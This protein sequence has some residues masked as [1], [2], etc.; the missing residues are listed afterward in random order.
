[1]KRCIQYSSS[2]IVA[3]S[4]V[5][6]GQGEGASG[7]PEA[8]G[9]VPAREVVVYVSTDEAIA[10]PILDAFTAE[11]G[12]AVRA[13]YD[14]ENAKTTAL[15]AMLR[16]ER[17]APRADVFWSGECFA[18]AQLGRE[19]VM[20]AWRSQRGDRFP[21]FLRG[22][23]GKW[24]GFAPRIRV[25]VYDPRQTSSEQ[26]PKSMIDLA[27]PLALE[28]GRFVSKP[29]IAIAD[30]RF[31]T[32][33]GHIGAFASGMES[34]EAGSFAKW[35]VGFS[36]NRPLILSGGNAAVVDAVVRGQA[37]FGLTDSDDVY[38]AVANGANLAMIP[39]RQ[40]PLG[41]VGG[42]PMRVP[43]SVSLVA[44][45][46]NPVE[47]NA[48]ILF[49]LQPMVTKWMHDSRSGNLIVAE[50]E[51]IDLESGGATQPLVPPPANLALMQPEVLRI[52]IDAVEDPFQYDEAMTLESIDSSVALLRQSCLAQ[53]SK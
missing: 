17:D 22:E 44:G 9:E 16:D 19:G 28:L 26:L 41:E 43:N 36:S 52:R 33:R 48:L 40:F 15:A 13:R 32:T 24:Y 20:T 21:D 30:P 53:G 11:S 31:G 8:G 4:L 1:M 51:A 5:G 38:A 50:I 7:L 34:R 3:L 6:C 45:A 39:I 12:I 42:G 10:R 27:S 47:A 25:L 29:S 2:V 37:Q 46:P 49:L 14:G 35:L 23:A 18:P